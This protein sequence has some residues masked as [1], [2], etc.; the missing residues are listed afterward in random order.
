MP[1]STSALRMTRS[2]T[3]SMGRP[4]DA[5]PSVW[6]DATVTM[7]EVRGTRLALDDR[8]QG[9]PMLWTHGLTSSMAAED[10]A[11]LFRWEAGPGVRLV[12]YD[13]RSHGGSD[14]TYEDG[15]HRWDRLALDALAVADALD[16]DRVVGAGASMGC[17]TML[18][19]ALADPE[20]F[21]AL[22]LVIPPTAWETRR[23]QGELYLAAARLVENH[24][25]GALVD[26]YRAAPLPPIAA[27]AGEAIR[28][29][30][31]RH[32]A[33]MDPAA[34]PHVLRGAASSDLPAP[35]A[36]TTLTQPALVLAWAGDPGHP[37][38]TAERLAELL[39]NASLQVATSVDA[40]RAWSALV[41][42]VASAP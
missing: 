14:P 17:A 3:G 12:R 32:L 30:S 36:L 40:V 16:L 5:A 2:I 41:A 11:G 38:S 18:H 9:R 29:A 31:L 33:A 22:V 34:L 10:D 37:V 4:C 19:A 27:E 6:F 20:R 23:D 42:D 39:P 24:G 13:A 8:G 7:I 25:V 26:A 21:E 28:E 1:S 15:A 35:D